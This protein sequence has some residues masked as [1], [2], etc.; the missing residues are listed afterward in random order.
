MMTAPP[1]FTKAT[2]CCFLV[3]A[4]VCLAAPQLLHAQMEEEMQFLRMYYREKDLVVSATRNAKPVSQAAENITIITSEEIEAMNAHTVAEVLRRVP[5]LFISFNQDFGALSLIKAQGSYDRHVLVVVD[6]ITWNFLNSGAAETNSIPVGIIDRIE[7]IKGPASSA[8]GSSLGGVVNI[9]TK[10]AGVT[11]TPHGALQ[12]SYGERETQDYRS[13]VFGKAGKLGYYLFSGFQQSDGLRTSRYTREDGTPIST[14]RDFDSP[15]LYGK[16]ELPLTQR[17]DLEATASYSEPANDLGYYPSGNLATSVVDRTFFT[18]LSLDADLTPDLNLNTTIHYFK[19]KS[20]PMSDLLDQAAAS[21]IVFIPPATL[22]LDEATFPA[23]SLF[24]DSSYEEETI[25]GTGRLVWAKGMHTAVLGTDIDDGDL[26]Q[27]SKAGPYL[28][29]LGDASG[30]NSFTALYLPWL[31]QLD[32]IEAVERTSPD[33][34]WWAVYANDTVVLDRWS[35]TPGIR[36]DHNDLTGSFVSP[37]F[38][39]TYQLNEKTVLRASVARGFTT[40]PLSWTDGGALFLLPNR[41]LEEEK[42]WSYQA[43]AETSAFRYLWAKLT[44]FRHEVTDTLENQIDMRTGLNEFVN[45]GD[46]RRQGFEL[47]VETIPFHHISLLAGLAYVDFSPASLEA[48][49]EYLYQYNLGLRYDDGKSWQVELFGHYVWWDVHF[50]SGDPGNP[51]PDES[52]DD[53]LWDLNVNRKLYSRDDA[54]AQ[55]FLTAHNL[56]SG[57]QH[58]VAEN[59]N[60]QRWV[61]AGVRLEF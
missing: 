61:E 19:Q 26:H 38:G 57:A 41:D 59:E 7:I 30:I 5:G 32:S 44:L 60:P 49:T 34:L 36:Y 9:I 25:G 29:H 39:L 56:F 37:S 8:W 42:V 20:A 47:E 4:L 48:D 53:I 28:Q 51:S 6:G 13:E 45:G 40:P 35:F 31:P 22:F 43:G 18:T 54:E 11:D 1:S 58:D 23:G 16:L 10:P 50:S 52:Y 33:R 12:A 46:S 2:T 14:S 27:K 3:L 21:R 15:Y 24:L 17:L 55:L